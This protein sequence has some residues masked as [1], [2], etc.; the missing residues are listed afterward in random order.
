[1]KSLYRQAA[2]TAKNGERIT[3][4]AQRHRGIPT[5]ISYPFS[6]VSSVVTPFPFL[7]FFAS[8]RRKVVLRSNSA[9]EQETPALIPKTEPQIPITDHGEL[10]A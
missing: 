7:E 5:W 10:Y 2:K 9:D 1:M 3:T 8:W 4:E 6:S